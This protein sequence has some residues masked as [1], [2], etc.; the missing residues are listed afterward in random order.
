MIK[1]GITGQSG[2]IGSH[3]YNHLGLKKNVERIPFKDEYFD[4][5]T[6]LREFVRQCDVIIHLA[7]MNRH[8]DPQVIYNTN[9]KLV[10][11][12]IEALETEGT[13]P[14][15]LF[16]SSSQEELDNLY[17]QSKK[18]GRE[19]LLKWAKKN[20]AHFTGLVIPNVYGPFCNPFY[21]SVIATFS[22]QLTH[23]ETPEI[24]ND[25]FLKLIYV[26]ELAEY[27]WNTIDEKVYMDDLRIKNSA[28]AKVSEILERL[29]QYKELYFERAIFPKIE[30][31][32]DLN[33]FNTFRSYV[34]PQKFFPIN[35]IQH[36]D[37]RG[38]FVETVKSKI[39]GQFSFSTSKP[40]VTRGNH[41]HTRKIERFII[42]K[43][44]ANIQLRKI[45]TSEVLDFNIDGKQPGFVDMPVW[46]T[47]NI[48]NVGNTELV[49]LFWINEFY[50]PDD[51]DTYFEP[52]Q[53][54]LKNLA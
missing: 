53:S 36:K 12:L 1:I 10:D 47:H 46:Y 13:R 37:E 9:L 49:A 34:D 29:N 19:K 23:N 18:E 40:G 6:K 15:V 48:S 45:G 30:N 27:F 11:Q 43:G 35:L 50:N 38:S 32:F 8:I 14:H 3:L 54:D 31:K 4:S 16:S 5:K 52:V 17:G 24:I 25:A 44:K 28:E 26:G 22:Y 20:N 7:A 21:N 42:I 41:Y 2:F 33:L 39:G 51:P